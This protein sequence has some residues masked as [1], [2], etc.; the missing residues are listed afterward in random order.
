MFAAAAPAKSPAEAAERAKDFDDDGVVIKSQVLAGGRGL[1]YVKQNKFQGG[2]HIIPKNQAAEAADELLGT[3]LITQK[4]G[5][6]GKPWRTML[7]AEKFQIK[8]EQYLRSS[9]GRA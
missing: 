7:L 8:N 4:I 9:Q 6:A 1:R 2:V 5:A 3:T